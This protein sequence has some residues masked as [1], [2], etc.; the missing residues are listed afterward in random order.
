MTAILQQPVQFLN[1]CAAVSGLTEAEQNAFDTG[2][3]APEAIVNL[4]GS[5]LHIA[6]NVTRTRSSKTDFGEVTIRNLSPAF[7]RAAY[8]LWL[9]RSA[10]TGFR[11]GLHL[12]WG[13]E[14][15]LVMS[16][17]CWEFTPE[18]PDDVDILTM[19]RF[20]EGQRQIR[21]SPLSTPKQYNYEAGNALGLWLVMQDMFNQIG[22]RI[23][24]AMQEPF[25]TA[26]TSTPIS[27]SGSWLVSGEIVDNINEMLDTFGLEWKV[28]NGQVIFLRRGI[29]ASSQAPLA[30]LLTAET[31]LLSS[32]LTDD[33]GI[34]CVALA[35]PAIIPGTQIIV[36]DSLGAPVG[37]PGFRVETV[38][39]TGQT[40]T[41]S[42]MTITARRSVPI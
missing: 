37:A 32:E 10:S 18:R 38:Q 23:D 13:S 21:E 1:V 2:I 20:G 17:E 26:V 35:Q 27:A 34:T 9:R 4:D 8:S 16:G 6:W 29:T 19:L 42:M 40:D 14:V 28:I 12:G 36:R 25:T 7:R 3:A 33:G 31:G 15:H 39:F 30:V 24:P 41:E 11:V 5:G 22:L